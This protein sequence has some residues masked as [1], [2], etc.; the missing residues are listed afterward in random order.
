M[1]KR[2]QP[3]RVARRRK[4]KLNTSVQS[5]TLCHQEQYVRLIRFLKQ[6][7]FTS[8]ILQPA[9]FSDTGRGLQTLKTLKPGQRLISLPQTCLLTTAAVLSSYLGP[10][11]KGWT[12]RPSPL[13]V[14]CVFLVLERHRSP[15]SEWFPYIDVLPT[16]YT[17][18][19]YFTDDVMNV[20]PVTVRGRA[21][22]QRASVQELHSSNKHFFRS[23][24]PLVDESVEKVFT[25]EALRW[26]W[27][28]VNTR[29]VFMSHSP[30]PFL[31]G[32]D[33]CALA[34]FLDLLNHRPDVQ[35]S[36]HFNSATR[37]YEIHSVT[38]IDCYQQAFINYGCHDNQRL[39]LEYG[40]VTT[41]NPHS[42]V[43]VDTDSLCKVL[44]G[45][46]GLEQKM[47][48]LRENEFLSNLTI[49]SEGPGWRLMTVVRVLSLTNTQQGQW[50]A[51]LL[52]QILC[53]ER[54][55][56]CTQTIRTLCVHALKD[57][58]T[59]LEKISQMLL[60]CEAPLT[61]QLGVVMALRQEERCILGK[62]LDSLITQNQVFFE[63]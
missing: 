51:V 48:F 62:C 60:Q 35:V 31:S 54:E 9:H 12:P 32:Q 23:L 40:F 55:R 36:A 4:R 59:A 61:E 8:T 17:C 7:G 19:V 10:F 13:L 6:K 30:S 41:N 3:G 16:A 44:Q 38:G 28:T 50:K 21:L 11:I 39:L 42:V 29:S 25:Y 24:Q 52:G 33:V 14:L 2:S 46:N 53:E 20:L 26:A 49:S 47:G 27:C 45:D 18:P 22:E 43:Y 5:V 56:W 57:T 37:C 1:K 15:L 58:D 63:H 34:P